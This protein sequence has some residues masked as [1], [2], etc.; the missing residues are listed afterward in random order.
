MTHG[1]GH[2]HHCC[3]ISAS[4]RIVKFEVARDHGWRLEHQRSIGK[5]AF[6]VPNVTPPSKPLVSSGTELLTEY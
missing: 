1:S 3:P 5:F 4:F 6:V 2:F